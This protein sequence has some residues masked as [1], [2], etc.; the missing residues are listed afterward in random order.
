MSLSYFDLSGRHALVTGASSG[1]GW[2]FASVLARAGARVS[3]AA[4]RLERLESLAGEI[5]DDGGEAVPVVMDVTD[6]ASISAALDEVCARDGAPDILVNNAGVG[7]RAR[8]LDYTPED[9][10][11][12]FGANFRGVWDVG[13]IT[14]QRMAAEKRR[15]SIINISS[16]MGFGLRAGAAT[17]CVSKAAVVQMTR[18]WASDLA[19]HGIRVN[20]IAPG[21][22][23]TEMTGE[24]LQSDIGR[25][26]VEGIPLKRV[27]KVEDLDGTLLLLASDRSSFM[28][29][30]TIV[31]DGGHLIAGV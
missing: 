17:Y 27:G 21:Y 22:F 10:D 26:M 28:T 30:T 6:R 3:I 18:T 1:L 7:G 12:T 4:R 23:T 15:G 19:E 2:H 16:I 13:Q 11:R 5:A 31:V 14:A 8:F 25:K 20:S 29:G 9:A 24:F